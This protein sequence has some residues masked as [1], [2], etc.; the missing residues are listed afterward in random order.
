MSSHYLFKPVA[1][2]LGQPGR[3]GGLDWGQTNVKV[4]VVQRHTGEDQNTDTRNMG[5]QAR[6]PAA[7]DGCSMKRG[8]RLSRKNM[9]KHPRRPLDGR[10][11]VYVNAWELP[12]AVW[13]S[14]LSLQL[15]LP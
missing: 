13:L 7:H 1:L 3:G 5:V 10:R 11:R 6:G 4:V 2:G 14:I 12:C 9:L 15:S 8:T